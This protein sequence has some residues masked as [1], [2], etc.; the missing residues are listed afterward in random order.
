MTL[1]VGKLTRKRLHYFGK[2]DC[3][4]IKCIIPEAKTVQFER[5]PNN[6]NWEQIMTVN[7]VDECCN[8]MTSYHRTNIK[9]KDVPRKKLLYHG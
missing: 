8:S 5:E 3:D 1:T 4:K 2:S 7:D 9:K 6:L